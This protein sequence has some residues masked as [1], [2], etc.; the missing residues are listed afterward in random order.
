MLIRHLVECITHPRCMKTV[1]PIVTPHMSEQERNV[2]MRIMNEANEIAK[3][4]LP[5]HSQFL[6][7]WIPDSWDNNDFGGIA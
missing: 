7:D 1:M 4:H 3:N 2:L 6:E 5:S